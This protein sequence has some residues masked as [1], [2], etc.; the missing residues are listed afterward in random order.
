MSVKTNHEK[1][2]AQ[3][4]G[5]HAEVEG[6]ALRGELEAESTLPSAAGLDKKL[7]G[8]LFR[9]K[10]KVHIRTAGLIAACLALALLLPG[11]LQRQVMIAPTPAPQ[12]PQMDMAMPAA[13][14]PAAGDIWVNEEFEIMAEASLW[15]EHDDLG[16]RHELGQSEAF[17][18][19]DE[20]D[21]YHWPALEQQNGLALYLEVEPVGGSIPLDFVL[22]D[23]FYIISIDDVHIESVYH[24]EKNQEIIQLRMA[25]VEALAAY[26][27]TPE[28]FFESLNAMELGG[29]TIY[30]F[31]IGPYALITFEKDDIFYKLH[32]VSMENL[33]ILAEAIIVG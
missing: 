4:A 29:H 24:F 6:E 3:I 30:Y 2:F 19:F 16:R 13:P 23:G 14:V 32:G 28:D 22:P 5:I 9:L 8:S 20:D 27:L 17:G 21:A 26:D 18:F 33:I 25:Y 10:Y 15:D 31:A 7:R 11:I 1:L 12:M